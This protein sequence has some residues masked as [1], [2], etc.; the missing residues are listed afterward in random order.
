MKDTARKSPYS[1]LPALNRNKRGGTVQHIQDAI[2]A[3]V[4]RLQLPPGAFID[5]NALC[6]QIGVSRFPVSE[7][8]GRLADEGF[9]E[10]LPQRGTRVTL[11]DLQACQ[12]AMFIRRALET[13][14]IRHVTARTDQ[15]LLRSLERNLAEQREAIVSGNPIRFY[16]LDVELHDILLDAL[17][18]ERV[19]A[20]AFSARGQ[21]DRLRVF[22]NTPTRMASTYREH[23][24][25]IE[26]VASGDPETAAN[27]MA[28]HL[29]MV[30]AEIAAVHASRPD[31]FETTVRDKVTA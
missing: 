31:V 23:E 6:S 26:A 28:T 8:L 14:A 7:A 15:A 29:D 10:V 22:M 30:M 16:E 3:A 18:Y 4:I 13:S 19:K 20:F 25:V 12:E 2:R 11:I 9:V 1:F 24:A 21:L 5:K 27:A 17:G